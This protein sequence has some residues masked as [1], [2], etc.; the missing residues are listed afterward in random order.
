MKKIFP[1][2]LV[3]LL[4]LNLLFFN[5]MPNTAMA[6]AVGEVGFNEPVYQSTHRGELLVTGNH[7]IEPNDNSLNWKGEPL[8]PG[9]VENSKNR[10]KNPDGW[11]YDD[12]FGYQKQPVD[13]DGDPDTSN[14]SSG[15]LYVEDGS[16]IA[17]AGL[18][19]GANKWKISKPVDS[20][21]R[22]TSPDGKGH[23]VTP[24]RAYEVTGM[25]IGFPGSS[26]D[27]FGSGYSNFADVTDIVKGAKGGTYTVADIPFPGDLLSSEMW[28]GVWAGWALVVITEDQA[29]SLKNFSVYE[30]FRYQE[31]NDP[32]VQI[33]VPINTPSKGNVNA[34]FA[35]L[36]FEGNI[37]IA[38]DTFEILNTN[39]GDFERISDEARDPDNFFASQITSYGAPMEGLNPSYPNKYAM[40]LGIVNLPSDTFQNDQT[41]VS[42]RTSTENDSYTIN[43]F[44]LAVED[45][46]GEVTVKHVDKEG[47]ELAP[48]ST[49][50]GP[51]GEPYETQSA[52]I[53]GYE[54]IETPDNAK[55]EFTDEPQTVTYVYAPI[56]QPPTVPN[57][58][59]TTPKNTPVS[60]GVVGTDPDGDPLTYEKGSDPEHGSVTVNPDGTWTYEPDPDYVGTDSFTVTVS[61]GKGGTATSTVTLT[62]TDPG[63][64]NQS[65][66]V[67]NYTETTPKNT[68]VSGGVVGTDPDGDPLTYEKGSDPE[69]GSVTVNPD[70]T[71]TYEPDPDFVGTDSFTVT[72]SDGK[73]GTATSTVTLTVTDPGPG[74]QS[75]TVPN[76]TETT[77]KNT[78]VS[79]GVVGTDPDG[80]TLTYAKG[81]DPQHGSVTVNPDGTWTYEPDP[82]YV[83]TDS[84]TVTVSDGKG[85]TATSTVTLTV[86]DPGPGNQSPT[87]PN[88]TETTPKNTPVSGGVVGTD[89]DGDTLTYEKGSDPEHGSVTV[90]PDG[91]WTYEPD[92]DYVGTDSFTVTVS[93]GKGGT[94]TST[95]TIGIT[96]PGVPNQPPTVPDYSETTPKN[97]SVTGSVYGTDPDGDSLT[98][99]KGS[100]PQHGSITVNPDGTWTY[101]PDPDFVGTDSF[102]VT[103]SDGK[104]GTATS[105]VTINVTDPGTP[106]Q[107]PTVPDYNEKTDKNQSVSGKVVGTDPDGDSLTY[108]K[109]KDPEHGSITVNPDGT[110]TYEPNPGYVGKDSFTVIVSDGKG[111]TTTS[112]ITIDVQDTEVP[113]YPYYPYPINQPPTVPDYSEKTDKDH[114]VSG[115]I[116][117]TDP[118][119]D[120]LT[121]TIGKEPEHGTVTVNPDGTWTYEPT[122][123]YVGKDSFTVTVSDGRGG[124]TTST[125]TIDVTD[126]KEAPVPVTDNNP[127]VVPDYTK[128]T[129]K[130]LSVSGKIVGTDRDGDSLT[131]TKGSDPQHGTVTVNPDGT[132]TYKPDPG[133]VGKDSFTVLISDGNGGT[134]LSTVQITVTDPGTGT[135]PATPEK[136]AEPGSV[137]PPTSSG[138]NNSSTNHGAGKTPAKTEQTQD[139]PNRL[140]NTSTN[141]Y[142]I[143]F[144]GLLVLFAGLILLR[145]RKQA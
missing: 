2:S 128:T 119:G 139:Q 127:P 63:P 59:E 132:W 89:P 90:N 19:W 18:Y 39:T 55:G 47:N 109:G 5:I 131:Y 7:L 69:H 125:V 98:Y 93:D 83:G 24:E 80:D 67:P 88:Y 79:G 113:Y 54:L 74:N 91:T 33:D 136:P 130:D 122:P 23:E 13:I 123:G 86:T 82:D 61:D 77:P 114:S 66:T 81:S 27:H 87:V 95:V 60:G 26:T 46:S 41:K 144:A 99:A 45:G 75:P 121:Y 58:T 103:V 50:T 14:S 84:F 20:S 53:D 145:K 141:L 31:S 104:G 4:I 38:G 112:T 15:T 85:G 56:N 22:L 107:P 96:D 102:T 17:W 106:N 142:N 105:T 35:F 108:T 97:T 143:G 117:G 134:V 8:P 21:I 76:Y 65:P 124:T 100:D 57:Y 111:G 16:D 140:P 1:A 101:E 37:I 28:T 9:T 12:L 129:S 64:G 73:G 92:P 133:Y 126:E 30:G 29:K 72:V 62:V 6:A 138:N 11:M 137:T 68:P 110:W 43:M 51:I 3:F 71:W 49:L 52:D 78:P 118:D 25:N 70:G 135:E 10:I 94:A 40:D 36:T 32:P 115:K 116:V 34:Q 120:S 42:F 48:S 44:A